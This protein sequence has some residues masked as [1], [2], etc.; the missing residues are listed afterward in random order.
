[1]VPGNV[2]H[3][4]ATEGIGNSWGREGSQRAQTLRK[5]MKHNWNYHM[6][7]VG[8]VRKH[9]FS[10]GGIDNIQNYIQWYLEANLQN[11]KLK[12]ICMI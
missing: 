7:G 11:V 8:G 2:R 5:C 3:V 6:G 10:G 12:E 9:P 4:S 1:M